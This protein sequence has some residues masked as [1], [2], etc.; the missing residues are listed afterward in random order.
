ME[1]S[2][3]K[4]EALPE[5]V[6]LQ[7][8]LA[9]FAED[10]LKAG[11]ESF[12]E[13]ALSRGIRPALVVLEIPS[14]SWWRST[15]FDRLVSVGQS[16]GLS[17]LNLQG[18]FANVRNRKSLWVAPWD[19]HTNAEGHRLLADRLYSL[20]LKEGLVPIGAPPMPQDGRGTK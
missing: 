6:V 12:R 4:A 10:A 14:D 11:L 16:A 9:P 1:Q 17:V 13:R 2:G 7:S 8:R 3:I 5:E 20:L 19:E 15:V 18:S